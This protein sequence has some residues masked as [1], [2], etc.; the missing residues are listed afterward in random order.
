MKIGFIGAG[1]V[2]KSFAMYLTDNGFEV[3]GFYNR[4]YKTDVTCFETLELLLQNSDIIGI[5]VNDDQIQNVVNQI[6]MLNYNTSNKMFFHMSGAHN[7]TELS[8]LSDNVFSLHPLKAFPT[9]VG[10][11]K[12][13]N[14]IFF[15]L[16]NPQPKILEWVNQ[17][18][19]KYFIVPSQ[20]KAQYHAAAAIVSNYLVSVIDF[21]LSQLHQMGIEPPLAQ[22]AFWPLI[23]DTIANVE[24]LGTK[25]ALTGPIVRGDVETI[26][27]HL[28]VLSDI[29]L[30]L[31]K[32]L[33]RHTLRMTDHEGDV[34]EQ[35]VD[36]LKEDST[37]QK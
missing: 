10:S 5:T 35:L 29:D 7:S 30:P 22:K 26:K 33:G 18:G 32:A 12:I 2:G 1:K 9:V 13:F 37:W 3:S 17:L 19:I 16:E 34:S 23:V 20:G 15:S 21:G 4:T 11:T 24:R 14:D 28:E 36:L 27:R 8:R 25:G 31:Y 6:T